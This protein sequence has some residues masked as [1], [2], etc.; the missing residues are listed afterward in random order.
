MLWSQR[1]KS[2]FRVGMKQGLVWYIGWPSLTA[3][4]PDLGAFF[5]RDLCFVVSGS[6]LARLQTARP[7]L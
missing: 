7:F 6:F 3:V 4:V 2:F 5:I 1:S